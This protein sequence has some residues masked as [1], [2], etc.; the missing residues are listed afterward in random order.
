MNGESLPIEHGYPARVL[1]PNRYGMKGAKWVVNI[2]ARPDSPAD[3][4]GQRGW[5]KEGLVRT[6]TRID[7]PAEGQHLPAGRY[8]IAGVA[9]A[10][11]RGISAVEYS[12]DRGT[13]WQRAAFLEPPAG[14]DTWV[15]WEGGFTFDAGN[16]VDIAARAV[17]GA[18]EP[19]I[20]EITQ[21]EP[22]GQAGLH[23]ITVYPA[24]P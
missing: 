2:K 3:W 18:G 16:P 24:G 1:V 10:G 5:T 4:Y 21:V 9:Y 19:Q 7:T 22:D 15:R 12:I 23:S 8:R 6:M 11:T 13:T 14:P 17:D 20:E